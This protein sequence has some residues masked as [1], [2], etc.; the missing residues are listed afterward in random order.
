MGMKRPIVHT[1]NGEPQSKAPKKNTVVSKFS[2][3][4][5]FEEPY[6]TQEEALEDIA[7]AVKAQKRWQ[8]LSLADRI[9]HVRKGAQIFE[10]NKAEIAKGISKTVGKPIV[11][12]EQEVDLAV[13]K[14]RTLCDLAPAGLADEVRPGDA[15]LGIEYIVKRMPKGIIDIIAPWNYPI[16]VALNGVIPALLAGNGVT[17][18][19]E[20]TPLIGDA[21][22]RAFGT[23]KDPAT[24]EAVEGLLVHLKVDVQTSNWLA[25]NSDALAHRIFTG[26]TQSGRAICGLLGERAQNKE[27]KQPFINCSLEL[28][29]NDACYIHEDADFAPTV[30]F[31]MVVGRLHTNGQSCCCTKRAFVHP[32]IYDNFVDQATSIMA[33]QQL[34]DPLDPKTNIGPL[35]GGEKACMDLFKMVMDA[36]ENGAK[37]MVGKED[38]TS[39]SEDEL[40]PLIV[41][42]INNAWFFVPTILLDV[43]TSM[44]VMREEAFGPLLPV[45]KTTGKLDETI[46]LVAD[47]K[48][49][50]TCAIFTQDEKVANAFVDDARTGTVYVNWCNDVHAPL[51]W[52]GIQQSGNGN[53]AM[54]LEG[55]KVLTYPKSI[56]RCKNVLK[57]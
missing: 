26:S 5:V 2:G 55:F 35:Y 13:G 16:F 53:G 9:A 49:G 4:V 14:M 25:V 48:F 50:L 7:K 24:G 3:E 43:N 37:V 32:N 41:K 45:M 1:A 29:G 15:D 46:E 20:T 18:K 27:L 21:F 34:G 33:Q 47:S 6:R 30:K 36:K 31:V 42:Q 54:G 40:K 8:C 39:K 51:V 10:D 12:S 57:L 44:V 22:E 28:G 52:S 23:F 11:Y 17:L 19:H 38:F 56:L